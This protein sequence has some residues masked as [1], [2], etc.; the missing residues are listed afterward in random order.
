MDSRE[1]LGGPN[2]PFDQGMTRS[3]KVTGLGGVP[4]VGVTAAVLNVTAVGGSAPSFVTVWPAGIDRPNTSSLNTR[5]G[6][7][8]PNLVITMLNGAGQANLY[9]NSGSGH[10]VVDVVGYF[11]SDPASR[12]TSLTPS[13]ILDTRIGLGAPNSPVGPGRSIELQVTDTGGVVSEAD[14]VVMNVTVTE[15]TSAGFITVWPTGSPMPTASN[16]NFVPD[17]TVP[18]LVISKL[19]DGGKLSM[20]NSG[21]STQLIADVLGYFQAGSGARLTSMTPA[22]L[23]DTRTDGGLSVPVAQTPHVLAIAGREGVPTSG[24]VAVVLNVTATEPTTNGFVTVFPSGEA[25]P[26]ASNLN[27]V[28]G[29]TRA[30][31][32]IAKL[33]TDG[34]VALYNSAGTVQ[35]IADVVGYFTA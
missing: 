21:G 30:N 11:R 1:G 22:R 9:N 26:V 13:R 32:V 8:V 25:I 14:S 2:A 20:F 10:C 24:V 35:L 12:F 17:Q 23:L 18:N 4:T 7:V 27:T 31:L 34:A 16:L 6:D 15:P 33:G 29:Q 5:G 3:L 19:G 28:A